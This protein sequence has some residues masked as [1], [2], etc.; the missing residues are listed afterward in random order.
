MTNEKNHS[1]WVT[2]SQYQKITGISEGSVRG[3]IQRGKWQKNVHYC[4]RD[5]GTWLHL[6][7]IELWL[8]NGNTQQVCDQAIGGALKSGG[9]TGA[10]CIQS[11]SQK[12]PTK[13]V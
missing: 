4:I 13:L 7:E 11:T 5:G 6:G 3:K 8:T 9:N 1:G 2:K 12:Q 10:P